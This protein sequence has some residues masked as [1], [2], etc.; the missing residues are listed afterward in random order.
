MVVFVCFILYTIIRYKKMRKFYI[1][2]L[3]NNTDTVVSMHQFTFYFIFIL[4]I[5]REIER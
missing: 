3:Y 5:C 1:T 2:N 4:L